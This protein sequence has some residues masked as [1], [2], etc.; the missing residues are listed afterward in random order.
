MNKFWTRVFLLATAFLLLLFFS[1]DF[2]LIDIQKTSIVTAIGIDTSEQEGKIDVTAQIAIPSAGGNSSAGNVTI[3]AVSTI[4]EAIAEF[5]RKTG[6]YPTLV[7][8]RLV[9]LSETCSDNDVFGF[10]DYFLRSEFVEDSCL[11]AACRG[12]ADELLAAQTPVGELTSSAITKVLSSEAQKTGLVC[13]T[14]LRDFAKGYFSVSESGYLPVLSIKQEAESSGPDS[15]S[16]P[17]FACDKSGPF[18]KNETTVRRAAPAAE[19]GFSAQPARTRNNF[20]RLRAPSFFFSPG[21]QYLPFRRWRPNRNPLPVSTA[22]QSQN[23]PS[24]QASSD[25]K[26][27]IFDA[28]QTLLF[29]RGRRVEILTEEE[30]LA[31]NL[32]DTATDFAYGDVSVVENG[33]KVTYNLKIKISKKSQKLTFPNGKPV[34]T[35]TI[36]AHANVNDAD[37]AFDVQKIA[38]TSIVPPQVLRAAEAKLQTQLSNILQKIQQ[39]NC[40]LFEMKIKLKRFYPKRYQSLQNSIFSDVQIKYDIK[41]DT[42]H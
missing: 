27:D 14:N 36:R 13:V 8:C 5:N 15:S 32:A 35:F 34:F 37:Q 33:A 10:L 39:T 16:S 18:E 40:D 2:G 41:F 7:H 24:E 20:D 28:A 42:M 1:N 29:Y 22:S 38:R 12:R 9:I 3:Q 25:K 11:V 4:G 6:W 26:A 17:V 23:G 21:I 30:T 19:T 31:F